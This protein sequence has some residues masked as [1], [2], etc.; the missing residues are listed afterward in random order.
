ML[1]GAPFRALPADFPD[2][3]LVVTVRF[4]YLPPGRHPDAP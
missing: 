1:G 2:P 3:N 4:I